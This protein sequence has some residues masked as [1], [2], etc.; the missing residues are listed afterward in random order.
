MGIDLFDKLYDIAKD[1]VS[2]EKAYFKRIR[3]KNVFGSLSKIEST[4]Q[5]LNI[6]RS[7]VKN[8]LEPVE[9]QLFGLNKKKLN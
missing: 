7:D 6:K 5:D 2:E 3:E 1:D 4:L 8:K 9:K